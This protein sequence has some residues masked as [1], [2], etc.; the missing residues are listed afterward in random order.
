MDQCEGEKS[1]LKPWIKLFTDMLEDEKFYYMSDT[2]RS[3]F[4]ALLLCAGKNDRDGLL[5]DDRTLY[6]K[7]WNFLNE[8]S[9]PRFWKSV[10]KLIDA[11]IIERN[12]DGILVMKNFA[13]RQA[14]SK[15]RKEINQENYQKNSSK[16]DEKS[17][18]KSSKKS[19]NSAK[20]QTD[21]SLKNDKNSDLSRSENNEKFRPENAKL[22]SENSVK[23]QT[24]EEEKE[25]EEELING[26]NKFSPYGAEKGGGKKSGKE[27]RQ[28]LS[29]DKSEYWQ[30]A[31]GPRA[32]MAEAFYKIAGVQPVGKEFGRWQNDLKNF[33]EAGITIPQMEAAV[34]KIR[35]ENKYPIKSPGTVFTEARNIAALQKNG[36]EIDQNSGQSWSEIAA[37]VSAEIN[38]EL[39]KNSVENSIENSSK[40]FEKP[41]E[42]ST[43][44]VPVLP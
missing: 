34:R 38:A 12:N 9:K 13:K 31:F 40:N 37:E 23:I 7:C 36:K 35:K 42:F 20:I 44:K 14:M 2:D 8:I 11:E 26:E 18:K 28:K 25:E 4:F 5:Y 41:V 19:E 15:S 17:E 10:Q 24:I 43:E 32:E 30:W 16:F 39:N 29:P 22:K 21:L 3:V 27:K 6:K 33:E 1:M